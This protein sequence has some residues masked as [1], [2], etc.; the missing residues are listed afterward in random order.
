MSL[1]TLLP[2]R[3]LDLHQCHNQH[4]L[5]VPLQGLMQRIILKI[6]YLELSSLLL[7]SNCCAFVT[8]TLFAINWARVQTESRLIQITE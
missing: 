2:P 8:V 3:Q 5:E 1:S 4:I 6:G 7:K